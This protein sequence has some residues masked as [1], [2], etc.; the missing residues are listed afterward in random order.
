MSQHAPDASRAAL[1]TGVGAF[2]IVPANGLSCMPADRREPVLD[3]SIGDALRDAA[4]AWGECTA[5]V[6]GCIS[7]A[8]RRRWSYRALLLGAEEVASALLDRFLPGEHVAICAANS[9]D[10]VLAEFGAALA[11]LVLVPANPAFLGQEL[12]H[13][14]HQSK[15]SGILVQSEYRGRDLLAEVEAIRRGLPALREVIPLADWPALVAS[16]PRGARLPPVSAGDVAQI[17]Y[18]SGTTGLPKGA[19]LTHRG[20]VNNARFYARAIGTGTDDVWINP[21]P[22]FHTAGCGLATL[23]ALQTGGVHVLAAG[24]DP[25]TLLELIEAER[26]THMLCVPTM[27]LRVLDH[28]DAASRDLTSWRLCTLGGAPVAPELARRA[29]ERLDVKVAIGY[30]QTEASPYVTHT[31]PDDPHPDWIRDGHYWPPPAQIRTR[32]TKASG[33]YLGCL[34]SKRSSSQG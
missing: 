32:P 20:L 13:L 24:A 30:G 21:M 28:Q 11:G 5:L 6:E 17:Q 12:L 34:T 3:R 25:A 10:W 14:L 15:A 33:S 2:G 29:R 22:L 31:L 1:A 8:P 27:L 4:N 9:A 16:A 19:L 26:G 23:G 7:A 18:T